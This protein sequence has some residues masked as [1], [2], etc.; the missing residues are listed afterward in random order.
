MPEQPQAVVLL[1]GGLDSA[2]LLY[3][4]R[5]LNYELLA[6][7]VNYKQRHVRELDAAC[8]L[9]SLT[10]TKHRV[11]DITAIAPLL[12]GSALTSD[13]VGVPE[14]HYQDESMRITV[15]PNRN[16]I[17]LSLAVAWAISAKCQFVAYAAHGGDHAIY[18]DCRPE[19]AEAIAHAISLCDWSKVE[20]LRP[21]INKDKADIVRLG[22]EIGVPFSKTWSCYRG[23]TLHCGA[24][25]TCVERKEAFIKAGIV[26]PTAYLV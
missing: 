18:P 26:D 10:G 25:G 12:A 7:S 1:S 2:V 9:A 8:D 13:D 21:F 19:F 14:G 22:A 16:M 20:L 6:L 15:V 23:N 3:H 11:A 4:L 24:C 17:M 5:S